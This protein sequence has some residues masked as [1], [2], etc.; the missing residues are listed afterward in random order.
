MQRDNTRIVGIAWYDRKDYA[1]ARGVMKDAQVLPVEYEAWLR[2]AELVVLLEEAKGS[3]VIRATI[4]SAA[5]ADW[6]AATGQRPDVYARTRY[7]NL[8]IDDH[9]AALRSIGAFEEAEEPGI[10]EPQDA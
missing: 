2:T 1:S 7:V 9:C 8:A 3:A 5:F 6:C 4:R 10:E